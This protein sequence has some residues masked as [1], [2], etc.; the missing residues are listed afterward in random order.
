MSRVSTSKSQQDLVTGQIPAG[1]AGGVADRAAARSRR[2]EPGGMSPVFFF[3]FLAPAT[4]LTV[5][6]LV[7]PFFQSF[8]L[9]FQQWKGFGAPRW[10]GLANF[11]ELFTDPEQW[12]A[13][14]NTFIWTAAQVIG[15]V[16]IGTALAIAFYRKV[17]LSTPLKFLCFLPVILPPT[18]YA[19]AWT[20]ALN[21]TFGWMNKFLGSI[22]PSLSRP[23]LADPNWA[24][25]IAIAVGIL[26]YVGIPMILM[27]SALN[28]IPPEVDEAA[29]LD[30]VT[31]WQRIWHVTLP[32]SRDVLVA[33]ISLQMV[34][35]F[36]NLDTVWA[37]T[38][39]GPGRASDIFPTFIYRE[40]FEF[41]N[42][43]YASLVGLWSTLI[44]LVISLLYTKYFRPHGMSK[45]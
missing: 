1:G 32:L 12:N 4:V 9:S 45:L 27:M 5:M 44:I 24:L 15:T 28:D 6:F 11:Q 30:G 7:V 43:G 39:G 23:W 26:Q 40:A 37:L 20:Y 29:T 34:G 21:P 8:Q 17:P 36:K 35:N 38:E 18:F 14:V 2:R 13:L 19:L 42:F 10:V 41:N 16:G 25:P 22:D 3:A 33:V 31:A